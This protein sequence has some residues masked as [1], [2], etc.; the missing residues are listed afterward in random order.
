MLAVGEIDCRLTEGLLPYA[1]KH[2]DRALEEHVLDLINQLGGYL[3]AS[4]GQ[5]GLHLILQNVMAPNVSRL[6]WSEDERAR[7]V[8]VIQCYN[9]GLQLLAQQL[10][11]QV[12]DVYQLSAGA[13]GWGSGL[14]HLDNHHL[15]PQYLQALLGQNQPKLL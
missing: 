12:L 10:G 13:E 15:K 8:R 9:A 2:P 5:A 4:V 11:A 6:H 3:Q 1:Q 7:L 14:W